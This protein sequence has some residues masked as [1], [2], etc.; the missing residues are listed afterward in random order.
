[1][2]RGWFE[3]GVFGMGRFG[4]VRVWFEMG[5]WRWGCWRWGCLSGKVGE[6]ARLATCATVSCALC[7]RYYLLSAFATF[8]ENW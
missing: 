3:R 2:V 1:M 7:C 8:R 6:Y 5:Y 4:I